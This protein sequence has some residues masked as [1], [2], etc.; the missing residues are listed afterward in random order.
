[1]YLPDETWLEVLIVTFMS[2]AT[3]A[4]LG[5]KTASQSLRMDDF[6]CNLDSKICK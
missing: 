3:S 1:M 6:E 5:Q 2:N 4:R